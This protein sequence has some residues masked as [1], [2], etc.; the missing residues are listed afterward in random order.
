MGLYFAPAFGAMCLLGVLAAATNARFVN[1]T[2]N[3]EAV[4]GHEFLATAGAG[5]A[6]MGVLA[7]AIAYGIWQERSSTRWLMVGFWAAVV[8]MNV[9]LGWANSGTNGAMSAI[10]SLAVFVLLV[11]W[12]LC[13]KENVVEYYRALGREESARAGA[14]P[15]RGA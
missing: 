13:G 2:V 3:G 10:I 14:A 12:Y 15:K 4:T 5:V 11:G 7:L 6:V 8:A 9:G 1:F